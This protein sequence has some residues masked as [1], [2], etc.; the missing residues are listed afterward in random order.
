[1]GEKGDPILASRVQIRRRTQRENCFRDHPGFVVYNVDT[2]LRLRN[3]CGKN[4]GAN[5]DPSHLFWQEPTPLK[6]LRALKDCIFHVHAK[7]CIIDQMNTEINGV[8]D[9]KSYGKELERSWIFRTV[10]YGHDA[11]W[12]KD[13]VSTLRMI[14]HDGYCRSSTKTR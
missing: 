11:K 7:D 5:F 10:G 6:A 1:M 9:Y 13:F 12:W 2:M 14:E 3:E 8:L 4:L